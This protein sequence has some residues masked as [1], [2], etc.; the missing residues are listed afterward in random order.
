VS[1]IRLLPLRLGVDPAFHPRPHIPR[2]DHVLYVGRLSR[3]KGLRELLEAAAGAPEPWPLTLLGTGPAGDCLRDRA[4]QLG[5]AD[6]ISFRPFLSSRQELA[7]AYAEARCVVLP[8]AH[9][10]FGLVAL[11][12]ATCGVPVVTARATPSSTLLGRLGGTFAAGDPVDLTRAIT[13]ARRLK[14][15]PELGWELARDH[16]WDAALSA[17]LRDLDGFLGAA[18]ACA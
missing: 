7:A 5:L 18:R 6:R 3:E 9:E 17:E 11:E 16:A 12:A 13:R 15:D 14:A 1:G 4:R 10:T 8:G 2:S